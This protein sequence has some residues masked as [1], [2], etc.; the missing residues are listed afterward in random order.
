M[1]RALRNEKVLLQLI[2]Q[3][4]I[5]SNNS[6]SLAAHDAHFDGVPMNKESARFLPHLFDKDILEARQHRCQVI[7]CVQ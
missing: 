1:V 6:T 5:A 2:Y 4:G 3:A 7:A